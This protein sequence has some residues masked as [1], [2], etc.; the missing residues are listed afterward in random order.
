MHHQVS[1]PID[2]LPS[3][4]VANLALL[5]GLSPAI[6][7]AGESETW[8]FGGSE[9]LAHDLPQKVLANVHLR[10]Q[11]LKL[12]WGV[13]HQITN[14]LSLERV[15]LPDAFSKEWFQV[16]LVRMSV[17][18]IIDDVI[19]DVFLKSLR[20]FAIIF[21]GFIK[22][23]ILFYCLLIGTFQTLWQFYRQD[24]LYSSRS[25]NLELWCFL[26]VVLKLALWVLQCFIFLVLKLKW[27]ASLALGLVLLFDLSLNS[28]IVALLNDSFA[29]ESAHDFFGGRESDGLLCAPTWANDFFLQFVLVLELLILFLHKMLQVVSNE[30]IY[31]L[32]LTFNGTS[33]TVFVL[34]VFT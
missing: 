29:D 18:S 8:E 30:I 25:R 23:V 22:H 13:A 26:S 7:S 1:L 9:G 34:M 16:M 12:A 21:Q 31:T 20:F 2:Q 3:D 17:K 10:V 5:R 28:I 27:S 24:G 15:L 32:V 14:L 19:L 33:K 6:Y 11:A 4:N